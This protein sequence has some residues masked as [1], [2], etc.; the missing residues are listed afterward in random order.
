M[1]ELGILSVLIIIILSLTF[2]ASCSAE[3]MGGDYK[4]TDEQGDTGDVSGGDISNRKL[5]KN[6]T[7]DVETKN[8]DEF[9]NTFE[10]T[11]QTLEGYT[12][13]KRISGGGNSLRRA[14]IVARIPADKLEDFISAIR[15]A[16]NVTEEATSV[17]DVTSAYIDIDS[18]LKALRVEE[19]TLLSL[20]EEANNLGDTLSINSRL[21]EVRAQI[22]NYEAQMRVLESSVEY[23]TVKLEVYEVEKITPTEKTSVWKRIGDNLSEGFA[24]VWVFLKESFVFI[25]SSIPYIIIIGIIGVIVTLIIRYSNKR[26]ANK[27]K[28]NGM[29]GGNAGNNGCPPEN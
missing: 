29:T 1:K 19:T 6:A 16:A 20:L 8:F 3:N 21:S 7:L 2:L 13:S 14:T 18:R 9:Q 25:I 23:S 22:E 15:N 26:Q 4:N 10:N 17:K 27:F 24:N 11:L 28:R 12:D 5:V